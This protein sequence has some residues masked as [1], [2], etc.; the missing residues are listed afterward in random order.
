MTTAAEWHSLGILLLEKGETHE[1]RNHFALALDAEPQNSQ[2][3][4]DYAQVYME[5]GQYAKAEVF[6]K[7][8]LDLA[9][10]SPV[11]NYRF[12]NLLK[13]FGHLNDAV[14]KYSIAIAAKPDYVEAFNNRGA[15]Y[16]SMGKTVE[17]CADYRR[18][19]DLNPQLAQ[20]YLNLGRLLDSG[21][22]YAGAGDLY[23]RALASGLDAGLFTHLL[24]AVARE[25]SSKAPLGYVRAIFDD[26]AGA[27]DQHLTLTLGYTLPA[28]IGAQVQAIAPHLTTPLAAV[29]LG[30]GTGLCGVE[31]APFVGHLAGVDAS[32]RMLDRADQRGI[33][34]DLVEADIERYLPELSAESADF[35]TAADVF[36]Y[37]GALE[38]VFAEAARVLRPGGAFIFSIEWLAEQADYRLQR[39]GRYQHSLPYI[40][41]LCAGSGLLL[42]KNEMVNLRLEQ[43]HPVPGKL[44][45]ARK[46][47]LA[48]AGGIA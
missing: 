10:D 29:D 30:C 5:L 12:A 43:G 14:A 7:A 16:H 35:L 36:I 42:E 40:S 8:A 47:P 44:F 2:Y 6:F 26:Y 4:L 17:A 48:P 39:T 1:A 31:I 38:I 21:G 18:A 24:Q 45:I 19:I 33:Y 20:A 25:T 32:P 23:R 11:G 41:R 15:A 37:I 34:H 22:D 28:L 27:F 46:A 3:I 9:P 13:Q